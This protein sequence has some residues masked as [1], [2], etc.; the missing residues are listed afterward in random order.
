[1]CSV[2]RS[3]RQR[4]QQA[5]QD[6][7]QRE[8]KEGHERY[9]CVLVLA[10]SIGRGASEVWGVIARNLHPGRF[11]Q[12]ITIVLWR[13]VGR[14]DLRLVQAARGARAA[15]TGA[16][17]S[18]PS[19]DAPWVCAVTVSGVRTLA[20]RELKKKNSLRPVKTK[21]YAPLRQ[22]CAPVYL[23]S[24]HGAASCVT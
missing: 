19:R 24:K 3:C 21:N 22:L 9:W 1:M 10:H 16:R 5:F 12:L 4:L 8:G 7:R 20:S 13:C 14:G 15:S 17:V 2:L 6:A 23:R 18:T 11:D